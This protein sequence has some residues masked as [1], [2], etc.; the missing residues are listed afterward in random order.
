MHLVHIYN[1]TPHSVTGYP[2]YTIMF[3]REAVVP[4]DHL[5]DNTKVDWSE[6]NNQKASPYHS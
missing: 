4:L 1:I 3:G 2:P 6:D 5:L